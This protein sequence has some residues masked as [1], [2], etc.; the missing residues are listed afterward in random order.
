MPTESEGEAIPGIATGF[1]LAMTG[2]TFA[3]SLSGDGAM[4]QDGIRFRMTAVE[5]M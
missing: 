4:G 5:A 2:R 3:D 1:A